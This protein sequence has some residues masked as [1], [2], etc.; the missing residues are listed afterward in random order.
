MLTRQAI[1]ES[2][3]YPSY[4]EWKEVA[5]SDLTEYS[6]LNQLAD[7]FGKK[8]GPEVGMAIRREFFHQPHIKYDRLAAKYWERND[9]DSLILLYQDAVKKEPLDIWLWHHLCEAHVEKDGVDRAIAACENG[10]LKYVDNPCPV[11][12]SISLYAAKSNYKKAISTYRDLSSAWEG[13]SQM[14]NVLS[15]AMN[16]TLLPLDNRSEEKNDLERR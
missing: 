15:K 1:V 6:F 8:A 14:E 16:E 12:V 3:S 7:V 10:I 11:M 13:W 5:N 9:F 4:Q 2:H